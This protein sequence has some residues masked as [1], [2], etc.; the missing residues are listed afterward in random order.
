MQEMGKFSTARAT[1]SHFDLHPIQV[2]LMW[3]FFFQV[4]RSFFSMKQPSERCR[5]HWAVRLVP[6]QPNLCFF[7]KKF[8]TADCRELTRIF[9]RV[10]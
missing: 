1:H 6:Q 2:T 3:Q 7:G 4:A 5:T 9:I 10:Y 8:S